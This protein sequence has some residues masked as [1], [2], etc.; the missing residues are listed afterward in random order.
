M[1]CKQKKNQ[2][3]KLKENLFEVRYVY[4]HIQH[5]KKD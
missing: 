2:F 4:F 1:Y 3:G 5:G